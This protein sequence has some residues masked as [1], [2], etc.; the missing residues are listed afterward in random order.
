[1]DASAAGVAAESPSKTATKGFLPAYEAAR[2]G[3][4][5]T[6]TIEAC[7]ILSGTQLALTAKQQESNL[8]SDR[9]SQRAKNDLSDLATDFRD[10]F[11]DR[12]GN[13]AAGGKIDPKLSAA[14]KQLL[15]RC[16]V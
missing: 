1:M 15:L 5:A 9:A 2:F 4:M 12:S 7:M 6:Y 14:L 10:E 8:G 16:R 3:R 11:L 13:Q